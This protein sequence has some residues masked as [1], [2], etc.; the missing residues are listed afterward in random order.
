[1]TVDEPASRIGLQPRRYF[2][3]RLR[4]Y[5]KSCDSAEKS[6]R[7]T[8]EQGSRNP[9]DV[10]HNFRSCMMSRRRGGGFV[11][12]APAAPSPAG[13]LAASASAIV[14]RFGRLEHGAQ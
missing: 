4:R 2:D 11:T 5:R 13:A 3:Y 8:R 9:Y 10:D 6:A 7:A 14:D 12:T 1:M